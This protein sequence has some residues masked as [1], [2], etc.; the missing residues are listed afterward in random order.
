MFRPNDTLRLR[1]PIDLSYRAQSQRLLHEDAP[2]SDVA[3]PDPT[4]A[5][6]AHPL[7]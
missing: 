3:G 1:A 2:R 7:A 4:S 5:A 6:G